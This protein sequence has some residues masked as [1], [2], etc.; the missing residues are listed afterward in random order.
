MTPRRDMLVIGG[1]PAGSMIAAIC[2]RDG[3]RVTLVERARFPRDK[4]CGEFLSA[5]GCRVLERAGLLDSILA[6]GAVRVASCRITDPSGSPLD[7][8]LPDLG[9]AGRDGLGVSRALLD[10]VLLEH[11]RCCGVEVLERRAA[12]HPMLEDGR[13]SGFRVRE[14]A[15]GAP[16]RELRAKIV[17]AADGRRSVLGRHLFPQ[18]GEP[19]RSGPGS[20]FGIKVHLT[21]DPA[22]LGARIEL[23]GFDGGYAGLGAIEGGR[24]SLGLLT[25]L[26]AL[27]ACGGSPA[28]LVAERLLANPAAREAIS[29]TRPS[30]AWHSVGPLRWGIR[31]QASHGA[32]F[33]GDAAGTIDPFCGEGMSN[34]LRSAEIA[35]PFAAGA[36]ERGALDPELAR[37]YTAEWRATFA[38]VTRRVRYLGRLFERPRFSRP[39]LRVLRGVGAPLVP[40]LIAS[41]RTGA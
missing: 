5:E 35:A 25:Q 36:I 18:L 40:H 32:L 11:A 4:V 16:D 23:H 30:G 12:V 3:A 20:W 2:A 19:R 14:V 37:A 38:A 31:R 33:V 39:A 29:R 13:V 7:A 24:L 17:V 28:R 26:W 8:P 34:A 41:T 6:R 10:T 21:A 22:V 1:G 15:S 9:Q 27:R